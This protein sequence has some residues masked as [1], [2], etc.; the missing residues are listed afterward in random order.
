MSQRGSRRK[1]AQHS[2]AARGG[3]YIQR[4]VAFSLSLTLGTTFSLLAQDS[5][6]PGISAKMVI[7]CVDGTVR[8]VTTQQE[9]VL[10]FLHQEKLVLNPLDL[11]DPSP[12][13][14]IVDGMTVT[15]TRVTFTTSRERVA[16]APPTRI[17]WVHCM[18][19]HPV[20]VREGRPGV[21]VQTRCTWKKDGV[22]TQEWVQSRRTVV[23]PAPTIVARG[24]LPSRAGLTG[25]QVLSM[26][27]TAYDP[28]PWSC[29]WGSH[30]RTAIGLPATRGVIAVDPRVIPLG[31][32]VYVD[33][34]GP[35]IAGDIGS[36]IKGHRIDVC[37][38]S[39]REAMR[40]GR[41]NVTVVVLR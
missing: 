35:A 36:A 1:T 13:T 24:M 12:A 11:C 33:G 31:T 8:Q 27:A 18:T 16:V 20:V 21:A 9:T 4:I 30:G 10:A 32:R 19:A 26:V 17:R 23:R 28:G 3:Q 14:P 25:R 7:L 34:Y 6:T 29:G 40:W 15:I 5:K 22:T 37:F 39:R 41:R 38:S 2:I